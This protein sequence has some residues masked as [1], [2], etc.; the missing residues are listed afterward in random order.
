LQCVLNLLSNAVKFTEQ[1]TI[2]LTSTA[3]PAQP[4]KPASVV[5]VVNDT[6]I[7]IAEQ[8]IPRLFRPFER[9]ESPLKTL[10]PGTGLGLYLTRKLVVEVL[11]GDI[12]CSSM[13]GK[14][15][16]FTLKISEWL[17]EKGTGS[18]G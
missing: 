15:S 5:I 8:D 16:A 1:G 2:S 13:P 7:G 18:R 12:I 3:E 14:G 11:D 9:L 17:Y 10:A 4:G 6:G